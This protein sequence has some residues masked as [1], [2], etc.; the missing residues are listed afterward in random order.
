MESLNL[1]QVKPLPQN[2]SAALNAPKTIKVKLNMEKPEILRDV[3]VCY[4]DNDPSS[5]KILLRPILDHIQFLGKKI[6]NNEVTYY[7]VEDD[8]DGFAGIYGVS[9][10]E[11]STISLDDLKPGP[12]PMLVLTLKAP[13]ESTPLLK[14]P[15]CLQPK[16]PQ[17]YGEI[18]N[19]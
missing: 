12:Q 10:N 14:G 11:R 4:L 9:I 8:C 6:Q 15:H 17:D 5:G 7:S 18:P 1:S 3:P 2:S 19:P 13:N 16:E